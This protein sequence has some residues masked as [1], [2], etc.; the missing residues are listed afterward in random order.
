MPPQPISRPSV[1]SFLKASGPSCRPSWPKYTL[2][3][4][5]RPL[6]NSMWPCGLSIEMS[7]TGA[8]QPG[9]VKYGPR[10]SRLTHANTGPALAGQAEPLPSKPAR[11][12]ATEVNSFAAEPPW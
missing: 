1:T 2:Q 12:A 8:Y 10:A 5:A 11:A 9:R 7:C 4:T 3:L 6:M